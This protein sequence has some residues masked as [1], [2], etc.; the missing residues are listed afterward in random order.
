[1]LLNDKFERQLL[2]LEPAAQ[3]LQIGV[4]NI[5][6]KQARTETAQQFSGLVGQTGEVVVRHFNYPAAEQAADVETLLRTLSDAQL[7]GMIVSGT[8]PVANR[9]TSEPC[10]PLISALVD[11]ARYQT[12]STLWSCFSAHA[13]V[14]KL[15]GISR[16]PQHMKLSGIYVCEKVDSHDLTASL[17]P[18]WPTPHSRYNS[19][20]EQSLLDHGYAILSRSAEI[21]V[22][23]FTK[24]CGNS[25]FVFYQG[26]PEYSAGILANEY[27]RDVR[28]YLAA[29]SETYPEIPQNYFDIETMVTLQDF[30]LVATQQRQLSLFTAF[31]EIFRVPSIAIWQSPA[32]IMFK[33]W[34][35][36]MQQEKQ[37]RSLSTA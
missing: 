25:R 37:R 1:M 9:M 33:Q 23:S 32:K 22:D 2:S 18:A 20:S 7:D 6:P 35:R 24:I 27:R 17:P 4:I 26:H 28:Q 31:S 15:D 13:A 30:A 11:W 16:Q 36:Y 14:M 19:I 21:G 12:V 3:V 29:Q 34:V 5:M 10:W 8:A